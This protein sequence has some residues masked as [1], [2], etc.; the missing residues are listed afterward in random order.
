M[1]GHRPHMVPLPPRAVELVREALKLRADPKGPCVFPGMRGAAKPLRGDSVT[2]TFGNV[3]TAIG[4]EGVRLHDLR[5][6]GSTAMTS[7]R[8]G[9]SPFIR[10]LVLA[11]ADTGGG[12]AVSSA[13]YDWNTYLPEKRRALTAWEGLLL[14]IVGER[15]PDEKV[16][17]LQPRT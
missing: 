8:L 6:T 9:I 1:K 17:Q 15:E 7:E 3:A 12:A 13:V 16:H 14:E 4:L 5:R 11:H 10:S 2:H